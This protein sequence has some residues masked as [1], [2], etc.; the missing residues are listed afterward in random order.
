MVFDSEV[1]V[2]ED[3]LADI[4]VVKMKALLWGE[5]AKREE[6]TYPADWWQAFK[7]RWFPA[8]A[9]RRWPVGYV[10]VVL[11]ARILYPELKISLPDQPHVLIPSKT[12]ERWEME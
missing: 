5:L 6:A 7:D 4:F 11:D 10:T 3:F 12:T 2:F 1:G 9:K 8:W